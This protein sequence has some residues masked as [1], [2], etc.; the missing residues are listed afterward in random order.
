MCE[1][2]RVTFM[3]VSVNVAY[4]SMLWHCCRPPSPHFLHMCVLPHTHFCVGKNAQVILKELLLV[5]KYQWCGLCINTHAPSVLTTSFVCSIAD[6]RT[7]L[8]RKNYAEYTWQGPFRCFLCVSSILNSKWVLRGKWKG[9][10][11]ANKYVRHKCPV[12]VVS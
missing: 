8:V 6:G 9:K 11:C 12:R 1:R 10:L 4:C 5:L 3:C 7:K 2:A